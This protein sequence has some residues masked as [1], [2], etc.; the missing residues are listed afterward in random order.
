[1]MTIEQQRIYQ[2]VCDGRDKLSERY[3]EMK[4]SRDLWRGGC[5]TLSFLAALEMIR[6]WAGWSI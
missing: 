4:F 5:L 3:D 2:A 1:M 6:Q